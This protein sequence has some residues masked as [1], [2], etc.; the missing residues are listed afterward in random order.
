[1]KRRNFLTSGLCLGSGLILPALATAQ[2]VNLSDAINKSGRQRML[3]QRLAKAYL[4]IGMEVEA[5]HAR[6]ILDQSLSLFDRQ[7]VELRAYAPTADSKASLLDQ[8]KIWQDYKQLLVGKAANRRDGK[9]VLALSDEIL[10]LADNVTTQL[11]KYAGGSSGKLVN[12]AG[13]Q[14]MLSQRMA[15]HYLAL[16]WDNAP[17]DAVAALESSRKEFIAAF[18][19]LNASAANTAKIRDEL[20]LAQQQWV[21]FDTAIRQAD[22]PK[23]RRQSCSN[24]ASTSERILEAMDK[25]TGMYQQ[26]S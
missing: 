10:K 13:R 3:S 4:Q 9:N 14:R 18:A 19:T 23:T 1:M 5:E 7:L 26:L 16:R 2:V 24:V 6:K 22:D 12:L 8:E 25:V 21:F 11:E 20:A 15:K 17:A